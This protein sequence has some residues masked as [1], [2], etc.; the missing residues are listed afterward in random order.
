[1]R[2]S[3]LSLPAILFLVASLITSVAFAQVGRG[4]IAGRVVAAETG[5]AMPG[6]NV[7]L[8]GTYL[9]AAA[10]V[11]GYY[12]ILN[13]SPGTYEIQA[14][15]IGYA[16]S[17]VQDVDVSIGLTTN[18]DFQLEAEAVVGEEVVVTAQAPIVQP[19]ISANVANVDI[20]EIVNLPVVGVSEF[21]NLQAGIEP[22]MEIR[23]GGSDEIA[24]IV[25]GVIMRG[26]RGTG[27][28]TGISYTAIKNF[29]VQT[30][31][32][33]AEY[34]N[35]R[36]GIVNVVTKD[37]HTDRYTADVMLRYSPPPQRTFDDRLNSD[38][39]GYWMRSYLDTSV[40]RIGTH[41]DESPLDVYERAEWI[42]FKGWDDVLADFKEADSAKYANVTVEDLIEIFHHTF[43]KD[44]SARYPQYTIDASLGGP[45]PLLGSFLGNLRFLASIRETQN[46]YIVPQERP[47]NETR[48]IQYKLI[49]DLS[50]SMK[51]QFSGLHSITTA[52][53]MGLRGG[54][55]EAGIGTYPWY[56]ENEM[57]ALDIGHNLVLNDRIFANN[58]FNTTDRTRDIN[59]L[60]FT[61][62]LSPTTF[63]DITLQQN[64]TH[65]STYNGPLR[66]DTTIVKTVA[67]IELTELP[68]GF[69]FIPSSD[70]SGSGF[71]SSA[72]WGNF[73]D[74]S[75]ITLYV[76]RFDL[77]SQLS[78]TNTIKT[79][80]EINYYDYDMRYA[81]YDPYFNQPNTYYDW[82]RS[83]IQGA[84][85]IQNK[86]EFKGMVANLGLRM[87]YFSG[88]GEWMDHEMYDKYFAGRYGYENVDE[89][90]EQKTIKSQAYLS[91][92]M[93]VSFP[94][95]T[96][97]KLFFNYGHFRQQINA[98]R[99]F[100]NRR[101]E[102]LAL[103]GAG[104]PDHPMP[105]TI[106]YEL[107]YEHNILDRF[108]LRLSGYYRDIDNQARN[109]TFTN[110]D[111]STRYQ[112][113]LPY[114]YEDIRGL[115]VTLTSPRGRFIRGFVNYT[116]MLESDGEFGYDNYYENLSDMSLYERDYD[117]SQDTWI[118]QPFARCNI[119]VLVPP[120]FGP[121]LLGLYPIGDWRVSF[122]GD[123]RAGPYYKW[124]GDVDMPLLDENFQWKDYW[125]LD[126][127]LSKNF[128]VGTADVQFFADIDNVLNIKQMHRYL[129]FKGDEDYEN[130]MMSLHIPEDTFGEY[131]AHNFMVGDD[132][133]G[134]V[135]K[136]GAPFTPIEIVNDITTLTEGLERPMYY[137][138]STEK[139]MVWSK[140][141]GAFSEADA[142]F[143]D[144]VLDEK[145]YINMPN[146]EIMTFLG[147]RSIMFGIRVSF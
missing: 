113:P 83:P 117:A 67:G 38:P 120:R 2:V 42:D 69:T 105:R 28:F 15:A 62:L 33:N 130:Y 56:D 5:E 52:M 17:A 50:Q 72:H 97:S 144:T 58:F 99:L 34:G 46:P 22:G 118:P 11:E 112:V 122:L 39:T 59:S 107:G 68:F 13:V 135:R 114:A 1:M 121:A 95:T 93:G 9:G 36:S 94:I 45:V 136:E 75:T 31:G 96:D 18:I 53:S 60:V 87:D 21:I 84:A 125:M 49:A 16:R 6:V 10:D 145:R 132:R 70:P 133:P 44:L 24:F 91:P 129:G 23:G 65:I 26:G 90:I 103:T 66:D 86:L 116:Y 57:D 19:D 48:T 110:I 81:R 12:S 137:D 92:R 25:D 41:S 80:L 40:Y 77:T 30:G 126:M 4:K 131:T 32:F 109:V 127:R 55:M 89:N 82:E 128:K 8:V 115:E 63:Y 61:H 74:T 20:N 43:R 73:I 134:D 142:G 76:G 143:V 35:V 54:S 111:L 108:L 119:E 104:N 141:D 106:A 140:S 71:R 147:P 88:N 138:R 123:W 29:Q 85:Y 14:S 101:D 100:E 7:I 3:R 124:T 78:R 37:V 51:L 139:Y 47:V 146:D 64:R 27:N 98:R 79:G 102:N